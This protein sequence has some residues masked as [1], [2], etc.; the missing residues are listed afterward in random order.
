LRFNGDI[1][2]FV[3]GS[4]TMAK[5]GAA[6]L[7]TICPI[8]ILVNGDKAISE[9]T[10]SIMIRFEHKD[11]QFDCT[12]Y[13]RFVSRF[14]RVDAEWKLLTLE[15]IYDRDTITPVHPGTPE[16]VFHLDEHPR[17]SYKCI[18]W[19]LAQAGFTIDPDLPGSDVAGS[20]EALT[21]SNLAWLEG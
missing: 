1:N 20:A 8:E 3:A 15:A 10:G 12:S 18:S 13:T 2:G 7:H 11:V 5:G 4:E 17:P 19:V 6:A 9:S 16:A 21:G 14:E